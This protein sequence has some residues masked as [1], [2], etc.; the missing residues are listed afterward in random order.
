MVEGVW[1][2]EVLEVEGWEGERMSVIVGGLVGRRC[3]GS[4]RRGLDRFREVLM[5]CIG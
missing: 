5:S 4:E 1:R 2:V 3:L